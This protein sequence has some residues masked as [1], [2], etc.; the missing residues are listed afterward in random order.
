MLHAQFVIRTDQKSLKF[1]MDQKISTP[2][3]QKYMTKLLGYSYKIEYKIGASNKV[4]D[5]LSRRD[6]S[7]TGG[8]LMVL[9]V[10]QPQWITELQASY[11]GDVI[12]DSVFAE[13]AFNPYN[14]SLYT[15]DQDILRFKGKIYVGSSTELRKEIILNMHTSVV[16][17][18]SGITAT[19]QRLLS[20]FCWPGMKQ[21]ITEI[22]S[23]CEVCQL[24][25]HE[26]V[27]IPGMLVPIP[28]PEG[29]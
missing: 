4:A 20:V 22:I 5:A 9:S 10:I 1:L 26:N 27:S 28:S 17:G 7:D 8:S 6:N 12:A 16:G 21:R 14:M 11:E 3:Q 23:S 24:N 18:H 19:Y 29:A 25:K 2:I 13:Q 15:V